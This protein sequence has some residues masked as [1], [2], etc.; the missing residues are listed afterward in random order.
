MN[1]GLS[2]RITAM[3]AVAGLAFFLLAA[4]TCEVLASTDRDGPAFKDIAYGSDARNRMDI[5]KPPGAG[6]FP[7]IIYVHGGGWWNGDKQ[8]LA[9]NARDYMLSK[10]VAV[11]AINY[12]NL[13]EAKRDRIF[14]PVLA[15]LEDTKSAYGYLLKNGG[16]LGI[17]NTRLAIYGASAGGFNAL[18]LALSVNGDGSL[19]AIKAVGGIDAQTTIDPF[20]MRDWVGPSIN[21]GGHAFGLPEADFQSFLAQR[22]KFLSYISTLSPS[23]LVRANS[24]PIV[25]L[26]SGGLQDQSSD[27]MAL[28]HS[29]KFGAEFQKTAERNGHA[30]TLLEGAE[31]IPARYSDFF[32]F[33]ID[34][35]VK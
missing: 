27:H 9:A 1:Y 15:A 11:V 17:D 13:V 16:S 4:G 30:V 2:R 21:Y 14:P 31:R 25:L 24:P 10:G 33:L 28:V 19:Q 29:P 8:F 35:V 32:N 7:A 22:D 3:L 12:R 23:Y 20:E 26:Y 6:P 34:R 5:Y 18:W